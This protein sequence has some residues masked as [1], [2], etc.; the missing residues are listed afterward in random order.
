M[1]MLALICCGGGGGLEPIQYMSENFE[2]WLRREYSDLAAITK[3]SG[4]PEHITG[5]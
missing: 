3:I 1:A 5:K 2:E 4:V